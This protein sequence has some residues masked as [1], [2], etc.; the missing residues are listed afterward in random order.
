VDL[1]GPDPSSAS[2]PPSPVFQT[3]SEQWPMRRS[4]VC[5]SSIII[6]YAVNFVFHFLWSPLF[7]NLR[8]PD[9][10]LIE[11]VFLWLSVL[12]L[13]IGLRPYSVFASWLIV[14]YLSWV[15]FAAV[16]NLKIVRLN[17]PFGKAQ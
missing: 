16:L 1:I 13:F 17:K 9:W 4:R 3:V 10:A 5:R 7:F 11:V 12:A 2:R 8:R 15:S 14:P 6:L